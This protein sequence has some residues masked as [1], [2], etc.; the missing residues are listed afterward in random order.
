MGSAGA[1]LA[2]PLLATV[3]AI[4]GTAFAHCLAYN[5]P[6]EGSCLAKASAISGKAFRKLFP[7]ELAVSLPCHFLAMPAQ[8]KA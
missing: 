7:D 3:S 4:A 1:L 8:G 5:T 6:V 2:L